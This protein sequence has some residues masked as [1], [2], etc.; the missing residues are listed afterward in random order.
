V[1]DLAFSGGWL[2]RTSETHESA[3]APARGGSATHLTNRTISSYSLIMRRKAGAVLPLEA[4]VLAAAVS[5]AKAGTSEFHG[6]ELAKRLRDD[7]GRSTLTAHGTL[8]KALSRMEKAGWLSSVWEDLESATA[9]SRPRRR[10]YSITANGRVALSRVEA[11]AATIAGLD[12]GWS[13]S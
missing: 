7:G 12:P 10:L 3:S 9:E 5:L 13:P 11:D 8:Y 6:F 2:A 4:S 1:L